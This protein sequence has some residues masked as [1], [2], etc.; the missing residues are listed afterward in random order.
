MT[1]NDIIAF[2][3]KAMES[4]KSI[5]IHENNFVNQISVYKGRDLTG[6][7]PWIQLS[8]YRDD[9]SLKIISDN[10]FSTINSVSNKDRLKFLTI[11]ETI[12]DYCEHKV[13]EDLNN[14]FEEDNNIINNKED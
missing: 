7:N 3:E 9:N 8:L 4:N 14:F 6:Y 10:G 12:K 11:M 1:V 5:Y 2:I 13:E